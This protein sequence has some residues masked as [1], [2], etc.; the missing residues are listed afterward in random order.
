MTIYI[1]SDT[2]DLLRTEVI[3]E[4]ESCGYILHEEDISSKKILDQL[5]QIAPVRAVR[6]NNDK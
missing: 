2:Y 1:R 6:G 3:N 4:M 5:Q